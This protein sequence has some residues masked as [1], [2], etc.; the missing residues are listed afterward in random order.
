MRGR[1]GERSP[2]ENGRGTR[3]RSLVIPSHPLP[4]RSFG[5]R[6]GGCRA[7]P[8]PTHLPPL[9]PRPRPRPPS[10]RFPAPARHTPS[11]IQTARGAE[12]SAAATGHFEGVGDGTDNGG[13]RGGG[14]HCGEGGGAVRQGRR[15][16]EGTGTPPEGRTPFQ[17]HKESAGLA[18]WDGG[19]PVA[20]GGGSGTGWGPGLTTHHQETSKTGGSGISV[21]RTARPSFRVT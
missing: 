7:H 4:R 17:A 6:G 8:L 10:P 21:W 12:R 11:E 13:E 2:R 1:R 3:S 15:R 16:T 14:R 20:G 9:R 5:S 19:R 18:V